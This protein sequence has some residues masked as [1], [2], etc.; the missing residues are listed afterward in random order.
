VTRE[1]SRTVERPRDVV[2]AQGDYFERL[3]AKVGQQG[4]NSA[5]II[6]EALSALDNEAWATEDWWLSGDPCAPTEMPS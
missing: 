5:A 1:V 2:T 6:L 3:A 4:A